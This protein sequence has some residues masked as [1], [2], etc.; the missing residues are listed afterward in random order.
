VNVRV[1]ELIG[2]DG[3]AIELEGPRLPGFHVGSVL[4]ALRR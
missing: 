2:S 1:L 4:A 3:A